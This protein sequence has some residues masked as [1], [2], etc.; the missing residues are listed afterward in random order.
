MALTDQEAILKS[1]KVVYDNK[2]GTLLGRPGSGIKEIDF[3]KVEG[4]AYNI[5]AVAGAGGAVAGNY[6]K[7]KAKIADA[8]KQAEYSVTGG[9]IWANHLID[10]AEL[11]A[12]KTNIGA[13]APILAREFYRST[14]NL[15]KT[16]SASFYGRGYGEVAVVKESLTAVITDGV[17]ED[18][19][20]HLD[21]TET[22]KLEIGRDIVIK[23]NISDPE[24]SAVIA[25]TVKG[26]L[27]GMK[28]VII[29]P[30]KA[31]TAVAG[32]VICYAGSASGSKP[33]LPIGLD[34]WFPFVNGRTGT[35][36][37]NYIT[38]SFLGQDRSSNPDREA[39][40]F[41]QP[42]VN[43]EQKIKSL[44]HALVLNRAMGGDA[45]M[46][47]VNMFDHEDM[48]NEVQTQNQYF[49]DTKSK[50]TRKVNVGFEDFSVSAST[51]LVDLIVD[52]ID[53]PR[54]RFYV[55]TKKSL[56]MLIWLSKQDQ[57]KDD[58]IATMSPGKP[59]LDNVES[60]NFDDGASKLNIEDY[61]TIEPGA[62]TEDGPAVAVI[63]GFIGALACYDPSANVVGVFAQADGDYTKV[64]GWGA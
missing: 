16:L 53:C 56:V 35:A 37:N 47:L 42:S 13:Y 57:N 51:N 45:D 48:A 59:D 33:V 5:S 41:Y 20:I 60:F 26:L 32:N 31:G 63:L 19:T 15:R 55:L 7:A 54:G 12:G 46:I 40:A 14:T 4:K 23:T 43:T 21:L 9:K 1:L 22:Q 44:Q 10:K 36:W 61:I 6:L 3:Q 28:G 39:G 30:T 29:T 64:L 8:G 58:G 25:G 50:A 52:D 2:M 17:G 34:A 27:G 11:A 62:G 38:T 24:S 49:S 18:L